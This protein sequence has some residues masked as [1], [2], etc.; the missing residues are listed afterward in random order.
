MTMLGPKLGPLQVSQHEVVM[1]K[2]LTQIVLQASPDINARGV[3]ERSRLFEVGPPI[4]D[5]TMV[6]SYSNAPIAI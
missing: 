4:S 2:I 5:R 6:R 1:Y 3:T